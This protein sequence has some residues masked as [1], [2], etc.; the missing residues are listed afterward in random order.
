MRLDRITQP[1]YRPFAGRHFI[2]YAV[3]AALTPVFGM[4][5]MQDRMILEDAI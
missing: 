3:S 1:P 4:V 2:A 5:C